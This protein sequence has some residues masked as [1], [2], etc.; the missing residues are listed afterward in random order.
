[1]QA[2]WWFGWW[3]DAIV[4]PYVSNPIK[5]GTFLK[6]RPQI[7]N[8]HDKY[9]DQW[10]KRVRKDGSEWGYDD[11]TL[12]PKNTFRSKAEIKNIFQFPDN[13]FF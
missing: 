13:V 2:Y 12:N 11:E 1:M 8:Y 7:L 3:G 6:L 10:C 5:P 4:T 9:R